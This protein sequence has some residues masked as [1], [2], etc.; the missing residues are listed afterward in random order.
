[1][2][3]TQEEHQTIAPHAASDGDSLFERIGT[4]T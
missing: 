1:M 2:S 4:M 3:T